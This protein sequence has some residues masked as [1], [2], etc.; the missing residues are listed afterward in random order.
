MGNTSPLVGIGSL[1]IHNWRNQAITLKC[2][3]A[4]KM[5]VIGILQ[6][7]FFQA[8]ANSRAFIDLPV[9]QT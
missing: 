3:V 5:S 8:T 7:L 9:P 6:Q 1:Q 4:G 2:P